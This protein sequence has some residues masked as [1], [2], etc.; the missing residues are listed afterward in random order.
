MRFAGH[1]DCVHAGCQI[2][3]LHSFDST[4]ELIILLSV[5]LLALT[6]RACH[7]IQN[8]LLSCQQQLDINVLL[9]QFGFFL[10]RQLRGK[11]H[12]VH[13]NI[14]AL[15]FVTPRRFVLRPGCDGLRQCIC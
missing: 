6:C 15:Q 13:K 8:A 9:M 10:L 3:S 1:K 2:K 7:A 14:V 11:R 4:A 5:H 12:Y